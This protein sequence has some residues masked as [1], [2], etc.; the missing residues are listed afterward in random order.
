MIPNAM[1]KYANYLVVFLSLVLM[2]QACGPTQQEIEERELAIQDSLASVQEEKEAAAELAAKQK[3][4]K[5]EEEAEAEV[6]EVKLEEE[7]V[8]ED[9][10]PIIFDEN[11]SYSLQ[12]EAWRSEK[13]A[14]EGIKRWKDRGFDDAFVV[15]YGDESTGDIW[16]RIR[17]GRFGSRA[18]AQRQKDAL[19]TDFDIPA[20]IDRVE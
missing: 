20:W 4:E 15:Q 1:K 13:V 3:E 10:S 2:I 18:M 11:G 14:E 19:V 7:Q 16:F 6:E 5:L 9:Y 12:V 17:L 8:E